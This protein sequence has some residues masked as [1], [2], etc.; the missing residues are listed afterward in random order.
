MTEENQE[1]ANLQSRSFAEPFGFRGRLRR[2]DTRID[3]IPVL[4]MIVIAMLFSLLFT[5]FVTL[6][7]VR[8]DLPVT[9][10]RMQHSQQAVAVLT[11]GNNGMLFFDG[12]VFE[13]ATIQR[14]FERY[15][16]SSDGVEPVLLVKADFAM[17]M[18]DFLRLCEL[19]KEAGFVQVQLAG[20]KE[21]AVEEMLPDTMRSPGES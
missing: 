19:A 20:K 18:Q 2:A 12:A 8:V 10:M 6:P 17:E 1:Y 9:E 16:E 11:I 21:T 4:D 15:I 13:S 7:G 14:G 3:F 5:R